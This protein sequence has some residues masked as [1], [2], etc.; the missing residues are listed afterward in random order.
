MFGDN[1]GAVRDNVALTGGC[2]ASRTITTNEITGSNST[3]ALYIGGNSQIAVQV[4]LEALVSNNNLFAEPGCARLKPV[5]QGPD[6][7]GHGGATAIWAGVCDP[8]HEF[9][10]AAEGLYL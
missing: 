5:D 9:S 1:A 2:V 10:R 6:R 4:G 3:F 7:A 8:T